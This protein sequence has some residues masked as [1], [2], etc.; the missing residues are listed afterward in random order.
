MNLSTILWVSV[1]LQVFAAIYAL[2]LIPI[3]GRMFAWSILS[4]AF[5]LMAMR[6]AISLLYREGYIQNEM[7]QALTAESVA[8]LIS[9]LIVTGVILIKRIFVDHE[10][11]IGEIKTLSQVVEQN[12]VSTIIASPKGEIQYANPGFLGFIGLSH[13][14]CIGKNIETI[15]ALG[16][17]SETYDEIFHVI[18]SGAGWTGELLIDVQNNEPRWIYARITLITNSTHTNNHIVIMLEDISETKKQQGALMRQALHDG[19][20]DLPNRTLFT[21]RLEQAILAAQRDEHSLAVLLMDLDHF[22][23]IN[24]TLGHHIGD[25]LLKEIGPR[26]HQNLRSIDTVARM[27]GD[28][29]LLLLPHSG[30]QQSIEVAQ[31]ILLSISEPFQVDG[32][33]LEIGASIGIAIYPA[34]ADDPNSLIRRADVAMYDAKHKK[35]G[36]NL[37]DPQADQHNP[38]RLTMMSELRKAIAQNQLSLYY[39]PKINLK[40]NK[41]VGVEALVRWNHP[42]K[43]QILP[44]AFIGDA[45]KSNTIKSLT[46]WVLTTAIEQSAQWNKEGFCIDMSV[47]ISA[48]DFQDPALLK[49]IE[50]KISNS[51]IVPACLTLELTESA[52]MTDTK[53]AFDSLSKLDK[54]GV[55]LAIDD[56]GTGYSSLDYLKRLPVDELKID[57]SFVIDMAT[58]K[59]DAAIVRST[60]DLA[61]NLGL[62]VVAEGVEDQSALDLL[63]EMGCDTMQGY[64]TCRPLPANEISEY[65]SKFPIKSCQ[66]AKKSS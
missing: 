37:Y 4:F 25:I 61:H 20:T 62:N 18:E 15:H 50:D 27:G 64:F 5:F 39:Q 14:N 10:K 1:A 28:E 44:D 49:L 31:K 65:L 51:S 9:M 55:K 29:F 19:L 45:E 59:D 16:R 11:N 53:K 23:E 24:D 17:D 52:V 2:R 13:E 22:K 60:I 56:F 43:G 8:L 58:S 30:E 12:P 32:H 47:N 46:Q 57:R 48:R 66:A 40:E 35:S 42:E 54:M 63:T 7:F 33:T 6:R 38:G 41:C 26:I 34:H 3:S 21:D 36:F